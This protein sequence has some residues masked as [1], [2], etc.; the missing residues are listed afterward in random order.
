MFVRFEKQFQIPTTNHVLY[1]FFDKNEVEK[2]LAFIKDDQSNKIINDNSSFEKYILSFSDE[3]LWIYEKISKYF[4][5][6][7]DKVFQYDLT[8]IK[9]SIEIIELNK[10]DYIDWHNE[11]LNEEMMV[12]RKLSIY[13]LLSD[14]SDYTGGSLQEFGFNTDA[15]LSKNIGY[16]TIFSSYITARIEKVNSG[17]LYFLRCWATGPNFI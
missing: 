11:R 13:I 8:G 15:L 17:K 7:N 1:H 3:T 6:A 14:S 16:G 10:D 9:E 4:M 12:V 2:V 5:M